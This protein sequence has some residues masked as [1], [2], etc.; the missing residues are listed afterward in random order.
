MASL[1]WKC[2]AKNEKT[3]KRLTAS[4]AAPRT[5]RNAQPARG[6]PRVRCGLHVAA[7]CLIL[8]G[9]TMKNV[10]RIRHAGLP[11]AVRLLAASPEAQEH[12]LLLMY[13]QNVTDALRELRS[14]Y[15]GQADLIRQLGRHA[16]AVERREEGRHAE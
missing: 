1:S 9:D 11:T 7:R 12:P 14:R 5:T 4:V 8:R 10:E 13:L 15:E 3:L 6:S 2:P 16:C